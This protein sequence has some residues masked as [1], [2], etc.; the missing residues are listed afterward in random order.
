[1][2]CDAVFEGG[3]MRGIGLIGALSY[4]EKKEYKW[5]KVGGSSAGAILAAL[6]ASGYTSKEIEKIMV[7][8]NFLKFLDKDRMQKIPL[9]GKPL[10]VFAEKGIYS[11][12]YFEKW[13]EELLNKKDVSTFKDICKNGECKLKVIASD[14][15]KKK[16]LI[17]PDSLSDYG[18]NPMNFKIS[19][20]IRMSMSIP[21]YFKPVK[22]KYHGGISYVVDGGICWN[23]PI[24]IFDTNDKY[25]IPT[26][27]FKFKT[28]NLSYTS[29]GKT[30]PMSFL[31]DIADTMTCRTNGRYLSEE[32]TARTVFVPAFNVDV[33]D[34]NLSKEKSLML[35]KSGY[36]AAKNFLDTWDFQE[37]I[38]KYII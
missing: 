29:E 23:Y 22:F 36:R 20:A 24:S 7:Q 35:F 27:G 37:Y 4:F 18:I 34:F 2:I 26:I 19:K 14:I 8:T 32:D 38:K 3:G 11:G 1:M 30:D 10:G 13:I 21:F 33:T 31:F 16:M 12:N 9:L 28:S 25:D 17:L 5:R 6:L 15:T